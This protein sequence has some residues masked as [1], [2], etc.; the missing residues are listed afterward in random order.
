[1]TNNDAIGNLS[2]P[3]NLR[4]VSGIDNKAV[5]SAIRCVKRGYVQKQIHEQESFQIQQMF[6]KAFEIKEPQGTRKVNSSMLQQ[7]MWRTVNKMK[8]LDFEIVGVGASD[9][10][11]DFVTQGI[12]TVLE[13]GNFNRVLRDKQGVF[14]NTLLYGNGMPMFSIDTDQDFPIRFRSASLSNTYVDPY[15]TGM[16]NAGD[17]NNA[18]ELLLIFSMSWDE[19]CSVYPDMK[20]KAGR[21]KIPRD[22]G[23]LKE[24]ERDYYQTYRLLDDIIEVAYYYHLPTKTFCKFAGTMCTI[25][26]ELKGDKYPFVMG[27]EIT[28]NDKE[29]ITIKGGVPYIPASSFLCQPSSEGFYDKGLGHLMYKI[30]W[31]EQ[32]LLNMELNHADDTINPTVFL[33]VPQD[34]STAILQKIKQSNQQRAAGGKGYIPWEFNPMNPSESQINPQALLTN[35]NLNELQVLFTRLD[36]EI[37]R[38]GINL[39]GGNFEGN[40]NQMQIMAEEE[41]SD[42]FIKQIMEYNATE[43][44]FLI[45]AVIDI[46]KKIIDKDNKVPLDLTFTVQGQNG[47]AKITEMTLGHLAEVLQT[48]HFFVKVNARTGTIP[49]NAFKLAQLERT[50]QFTPPGSKAFNDIAVDMARLNGRDITAN[51]LMPAQQQA[52]APQQIPLQNAQPIATGTDRISINPKN[53]IATPAF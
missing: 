20:N 26:S 45:E 37:R 40:P 11:N 35:N 22:Y 49:S 18:Q 12:S 5:Q 52:P 43:T 25:I 44:Q 34:T 53:K 31:L 15:A 14:F 6:Q 27:G 46:T 42:S 50:S 16:R 2:T 41:E 47:E 23:M 39:D 21:G 4:V 13:R 19:F 36:G 9:E 29:E 1:M 3:P 17:E 10:L 7:G 28:K 38:L 30:A 51:D 33:N 32:R 24:I 48:Y 8:C